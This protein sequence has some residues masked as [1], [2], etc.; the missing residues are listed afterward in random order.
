MAD[1]V[2]QGIGHLGASDYGRIERGNSRSCTSVRNTRRSV[3]GSGFVPR[4]HARAGQRFAVFYTKVHNRLLRPLL[5]AD[6]PPAP[7]PVRQALRT[8]DR[9]VTDYV[10]E[11]R[12]TA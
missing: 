11:A 5:A 6:R 4:I 12:M 2:A 1:D 8:L 7:L 3:P 10:S 9:A